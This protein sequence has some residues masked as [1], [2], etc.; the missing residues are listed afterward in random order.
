MPNRRLRKNVRAVV[1]PNYSSTDSRTS[2]IIPVSQQLDLPS[3]RSRRSPKQLTANISAS[4]DADAGAA[5]PPPPATRFSRIR[6]VQSAGPCVQIQNIRQADNAHQPSRQPGPRQRGRG[7]RR[8]HGRW[9]SRQWRGMRMRCQVRI[10]LWWRWQ[11]RAGVVG[12]LGIDVGRRGVGAGQGSVGCWV[13]G[14]LSDNCRMRD[15][16]CRVRRCRRPRRR[17]RQWIGYP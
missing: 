4:P 11:M 1:R 9:Q 2:Q 16:Y 8:G 14:W 7:D 12:R 3:C 5:A 13:G 6:R 10:Q 17:W 15:M